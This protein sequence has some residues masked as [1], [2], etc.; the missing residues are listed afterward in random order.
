MPTLEDARLG[1]RDMGVW[2]RQNRNL[3]M[4]SFGFRQFEHLLQSPF[5]A[6]LHGESVSKS[7]FRVKDYLDHELIPRIKSGKNVLVITHH[8]ILEMLGMLLNNMAPELYAPAALP[9]AQLITEDCE[10]N[11]ARAR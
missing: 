10:R 3:L 8:W 4:Q 7:F 9:V 11:P 1:D 5:A 2:N 6:P